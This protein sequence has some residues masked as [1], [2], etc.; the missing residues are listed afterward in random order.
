MSSPKD[1]LERA[2]EHCFFAGVGDSGME[3]CEALVPFGVAKIHAVQETLGHAPDAVFVGAPD[4]TVTRNVNRW[5][6]GF[7]YGGSYAW[8]GDFAVLDIKS[9]ACGMLVGAL[10]GVPPVEEVR[11]R[12]ERLKQG[13][14]KLDGIELDYDLEESNHFV[15]AFEVTSTKGAP[16]P[17]AGGAAPSIA[18]EAPLGA[19]AFFIMHSSGHEHRGPSGLGPG[20]YYDESEELR[21]SARTIATPWGEC[22]VLAGADAAAWFQAYAR[23]QDFNHRR[24][25]AVAKALFGD[26]RPVVNE[27]HQGLVRG[28]NRAN[29]GVYTYDAPGALFPLTLSATLPAYLVRGHENVT[30][31]TMTRLGW[32]ERARR[33]VGREPSDG[34]PRDHAPDELRREPERH[35]A[36]RPRRVPGDRP[37]AEL[38]RDRRPARLVHHERHEPPHALRVPHRGRRRREHE[39]V[40]DQHPRHRASRPPPPD[41]GQREREHDDVEHRLGEHGAGQGGR[42]RLGD[43]HRLR[44]RLADRRRQRRQEADG[45][46][47]CG[48]R[49]VPGLERED[50]SHAALLQDPAR[51]QLDHRRS[52][53]ERRHPVQHLGPAVDILELARRLDH[54]G[55]AAVGDLELPRAVGALVHRDDL[56]ELRVLVPAAV[57]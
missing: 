41:H 43:Q 37:H 17:D 26:F 13:G 56:L 45:R 9:N 36:R 1:A 32:D 30:A 16:I 53:A 6:Q 29:V 15:D 44:D 7:G 48:H 50:R 23:V 38:H 2:R 49:A 14:L 27:T 47:A 19:K 5:K 31:A 46:Q 40:C 55:R 28:V 22:R 42:T 24:R 8:S 21:K 57:R 35:Q 12:A 4:A 11:A 51:R 54:L 39:P 52:E 33:P 20:L 34:G 10:D 25:E 18:E 3:L